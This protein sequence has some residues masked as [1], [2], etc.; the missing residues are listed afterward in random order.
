MQLIAL[1]KKYKWIDEEKK[2]FGKEGTGYEFTGCTGERFRKELDANIARKEELGRKVNLKA[3]HMLASAEDQV[4]QGWGE[5][6]CGSHPGAT[7]G[8]TQTAVGTG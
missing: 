8:R 7:I 1:A 2:H 3:M 6:H 4:W 5:V